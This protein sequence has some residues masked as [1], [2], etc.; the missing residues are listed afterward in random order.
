MR[1][2]LIA[3]A[4]IWGGSLFA[5]D[6]GLLSLVMPDA[7]VLAGVNVEQVKASPLGRYYLTRIAQ[8]RASDPL[9]SVDI[10]GF[11]MWRDLREVFFSA[12]GL[13]KESSGLVVARGTFDV[14]KI[15]AEAKAGNEAIETYHGVE[16]IDK[17]PPVAF[18]DATLAITGDPAS[19]HA[20]IDRR[21]APTVMSPA[22]ALQVSQLSS[23]MDAWIFAYTASS[24]PA[25]HDLSGILAKV[26]QI[27]GGVRLGAQIVLTLQAVSQTDADAA[28]FAEMVKVMGLGTA[29]PGAP[30]ALMQ[31]GQALRITVEGNTTKISL[32]VPEALIEEIFK[33]PP[34]AERQ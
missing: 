16:I 12:S 15:I 22:M 26:Q 27:S 3:A 11:D 1:L 10:T 18:L 4:T 14:S 29:A 20:A 23:T 25:P 17:G 5:A 7:R 33:N 6:P 8:Q 34:A 30:A 28:S 19:V 9:H 24:G 32:S 2:P 13:E 21:Q 31:I